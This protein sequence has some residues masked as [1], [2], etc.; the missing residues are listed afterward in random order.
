MAEPGFFLRGPTNLLARDEARRIAINTRDAHQGWLRHPPRHLPAVAGERI[1][2]VGGVA[3]ILQDLD[4]APRP[5]AGR[6]ARR[7]SGRCGCRGRHNHDHISLAHDLVASVV[8]SVGCPL[9]LFTDP[10]VVAARALPSVLAASVAAGFIG[11]PDIHH[12]VG[13]ARLDE[14]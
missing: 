10:T 4:Q 5:R 13:F 7:R 3:I 2:L 9:L 12:L 6:T 8:A 14:Y 11:H 1:A